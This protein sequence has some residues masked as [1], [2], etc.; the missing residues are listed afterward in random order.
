MLVG[1]A[2]FGMASDVIAIVQGNYAIAWFKTTDLNLVFGIQLTLS[3]LG[4]TVNYWVMEPLYQ[5]AKGSFKEYE[6]IGMAIL[7]G[8][9]NLINSKSNLF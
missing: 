2:C 9:Y 1:R 4:S 5:W 7:I 6:A 3:R 8:K